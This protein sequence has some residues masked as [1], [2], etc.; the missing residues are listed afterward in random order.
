MIDAV[1]T[2][3]VGDKRSLPARTIATALR[4]QLEVAAEP[5]EAAR[6]P[7]WSGYLSLQ[8]N[9]RTIVWSADGLVHRACGLPSARPFTT[10]R[11]ERQADDR[12]ADCSRIPESIAITLGT[13]LG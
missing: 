2:G 11:D 7:Q 13:G 10:S 5:R 3:R 9:F 6:L 4:H 1:A 12:Y 8:P